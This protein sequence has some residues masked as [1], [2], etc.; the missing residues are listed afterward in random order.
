MSVDKLLKGLVNKVDMVESNVKPE[1]V[2]KIEEKI[3]FGLNESK[4]I[5]NESSDLLQ[6]IFGKTK[7]N[8]KKDSLSEYDEFRLIMREEIES[9]FKNKTVLTENKT[10]GPQTIYLKIGEHVFKGTMELVQ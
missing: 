10:D 3:D 4:I 5:K 6:S 8:D 9:F 1:P 7:I 2:K